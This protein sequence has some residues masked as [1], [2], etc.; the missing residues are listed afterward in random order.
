M[1]VH[2]TPLM[3]ALLLLLMAGGPAAAQEFKKSPSFVDKV[4]VTDG[5]VTFQTREGN[6]ADFTLKVV[7]P[8]DFFLQQS[9]AGED[10]PVL[11]ITTEQGV[12]FPDGSYTLE[13]TARPVITNKQRAALDQARQKGDRYQIRQLMKE[14]GIDPHEMVHSIYL[15]IAEGKFINP[16]GEEAEPEASGTNLGSL[17]GAPVKNYDRAFDSVTLT[18][19]RWDAAYLPATPNATGA[20]AQQAMLVSNDNAMPFARAAAPTWYEATFENTT[21]DG[22]LLSYHGYLRPVAYDGQG[23]LFQ[24]Y[25]RSA[26]GPVDDA[27]FRG[28]FFSENGT[29]RFLTHAEVTRPAQSA[30]L[31]DY[32]S[33]DDQAGGVALPDQVITD[34]LIVNGGSLCVGLDCSNGESFGFETIRLKE[35]NLRIRAFDTSTS[36]SFPSRDWQITFNESDNGGKNKYSIDDIDGGRTPFTIEAGARTNAL[37]VEDGGR[38]GIGTPTPVADLHVKTGNTPTLRLEQDGTSGFAAQTWDL[39]GN[40]ANLFIRDATNG[41]D[42]PFRIYPDAGTN[43]LVIEGGT[44]DVGV[45]TNTPTAPLHVRRANGTARALIEEVGSGAFELLELSNNGGVQFQLNNSAASGVGWNIINVGNA[46]NDLRIAEGPG[47]TQFVLDPSGNLT[48]DGAINAASKP[49]RIDH[50]LDPANK[51][52]FH[53]A[54]ESP[55][56]MNVYNGNIVLDRRG[57]AIVELPEYFEALNQDFRYQL[58]PI[59]APGPNL[60]VAQEIENNRFVIEGGEPGMT[61]SWQVSGIRHDPWAEQNRIQ[62]EVDKEEA[63]GFYVHPQLYNQ[64]D[65]RRLGN[66][67]NQKIKV[68]Q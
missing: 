60:Y 45:G 63:R 22:T 34:D 11:N 6:Y 13:M 32:V 31:F 16:H 55:D 25:Y 5:A 68:Q 54:I 57:R 14:I 26:Q 48:V 43:A 36:A 52:L 20:D 67:P 51:F 38:I 12:T 10:T 1:K 42:L 37:Y 2:F 56:M 18:G 30:P 61:V 28:Y 35:N 39:A 15:T 9:F 58:T 47:S 64:P 49:F 44:G 46:N 29:I 50:P 3:L 41:S 59:G 23:K 27:W 33:Q 40:E 24:A 8:E 53:N 21:D 7:G 19:Q 65:E 66:A 4:N 17:E 62:V